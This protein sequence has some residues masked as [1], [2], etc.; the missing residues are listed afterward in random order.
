MEAKL[1][2]LCAGAIVVGGGRVTAGGLRAAR[3]QHVSAIITGG[4][5]DQGFAR[6]S[7][8]RSGVATTG[9]ERVGLTLIITEG[10][11]DVAMADR[12]W[13]LL[14]SR[15]GLAAACNGATRFGPECCVPKS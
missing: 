3:E 1:T 5:D 11:G 4:I 10:F 15:S 13:S 14:H 6:L 12:T 9:S 7:G 8:L 2:P